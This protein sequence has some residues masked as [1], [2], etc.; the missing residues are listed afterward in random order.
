MLG[1]KGIPYRGRVTQF[2]GDRHSGKSLLC[3]S[4]V[5]AYQKETGLPAVIFDTEDS[6]EMAFF[7]SLGLNTAP[8]ML[9]VR[10]MTDWSEILAAAVDYLEAGARM[11]VIDSLSEGGKRASRK[12]ISQGKALSTQP[13]DH[14]KGFS[15]FL[16]QLSPYLSKYDAALLLVNQTRKRLDF[17]FAAALAQ[18]YPSPTNWPYILTGGNAA[19]FKP[20]IMVEMLIGDS[21]GKTYKEPDD[22]TKWIFEKP[23]SS[24]LAQEFYIQRS[25]ATV[26]KNKFTGSGYRRFNIWMRPGSGVD[27]NASLRELA[28]AFGIIRKDGKSWCVG[29][30]G[31][32]PWEVFPTEETGIRKLV[33]ENDPRL[34]GLLEKEVYRMLD[35]DSAGE[36]VV[37]I[38]VAED[39]S[40][41]EGSEYATDASL[42]TELDFESD[43]L[44]DSLT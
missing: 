36:V 25:R 34:M 4:A 14:A 3:Y 32:E 16:K 11:I 40:V 35:L 44:P 7:R 24:G 20:T 22:K 9:A 8:D 19:L 29:P 26:L 6:S 18:K 37:T 12:E 5:K 23:K 28:L 33:E 38:E 42:D 10:Q 15:N 27:N 2:H 39:K 1:I 31:A 21:M 41:G 43:D 13:G 17:S 30:V